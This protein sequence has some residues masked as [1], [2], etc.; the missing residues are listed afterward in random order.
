MATRVNDV[1]NSD[2]NVVGFVIRSSVKEA[3]FMN[4]RTNRFDIK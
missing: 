4:L 3:Y 2:M 1:L